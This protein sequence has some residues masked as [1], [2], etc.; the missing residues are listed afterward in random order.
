MTVVASMAVGSATVVGE[1]LSTVGSGSDD[2]L[3]GTT[4]SASS[5][6]IVPVTDGTASAPTEVTATSSRVAPGGTTPGSGRT[7]RASMRPSRPAPTSK[8]TTVPASIWRV[9]L[10][11]AVQWNGRRRPGP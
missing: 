4:G 11:M 3:G 9:P 2:R 8:A 7:E 5:P 10:V 1:G 6:A